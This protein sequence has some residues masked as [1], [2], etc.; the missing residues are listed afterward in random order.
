MSAPLP[1]ETVFLNAIE[2]RLCKEAFPRLEQLLQQLPEE[3]MWTKDNSFCNSPGNLALHLL[4]NTRQ[5]LLAGIGT[6]PDVRERDKEFEEQY[7]SKEDLILKVKELRQSVSQLL[8]T[9][10]EQQLL[11]MYS[12]QGFNMSG[13]DALVHVAEHFSYHT[14]Q[15]ALLVKQRMAIDTGF[16]AGMN[17]NTTGNA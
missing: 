1:W 15:V 6:Q 14:G 13:L 4:G 11:C 7:L 16:Y 5:Y 9:L 3:Q 17:L 10:T 12:I 2:L 8:P